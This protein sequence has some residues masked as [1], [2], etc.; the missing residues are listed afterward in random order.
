MT[1][2]IKPGTILALP[3]RQAKTH[4]PRVNHKL[5]CVSKVTAT[6][7]VAV[8]GSGELRVRLSD[9]KVVGEDYKYAIVADEAFQALHEQQKEALHRY[10]QATLTVN[11]LIDVPAHRLQLSLRQIEALAKAWTEIKQIND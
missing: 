1:T 7:A 8:S 9:L 5:Y 3:A 11:D 2:E 10:T 6:Q 4:W